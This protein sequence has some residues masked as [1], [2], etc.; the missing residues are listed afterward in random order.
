ML[1]WSLWL[2]NTSDYGHLSLDFSLGT[3]QV[4]DGDACY[5]NESYMEDLSYARKKRGGGGIRQL[6]LHEDKGRR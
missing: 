1:Y 4:I 6:L 2:C 3:S 5:K